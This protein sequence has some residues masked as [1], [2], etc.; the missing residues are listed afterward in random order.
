MQIIKRQLLLAL[1]I[2][3]TNVMA[4]AQS[5]TVKG[6]VTDTGGNPIIGASVKEQ[7]T[8]NA[9][10]TDVD[11]RFQLTVPASST[12]EISYIGY[13]TQTLKPKANVAVTLQ[14]QRSELNEVVVIG[15]GT[16]R[17]KDLTGSVV[18]IRP[19]Q[20]ADQNPQTVQDVLRGHAG[21]N[22]GYNA[23]AKGGGS[24]NIRGQRSV[25]TSNNHNSP[26]LILDGMMFYGELS[27]INPDDIAQ[28]DVLKD[29]SSAAI[30][31]AKAANGVIIIT[32]KKGKVGKPTVNL[33]A[34]VGFATKARYRDRMNTSQYL[35]H[36]QE[37]YEQNFYGTDENGNYGY[38]QSGTYKDQPGF[39]S[40]PDNLPSGVSLDQ[41]RSYSQNESG[42]SD[43][44]I[45]ARRLGFEGNNLANFLAGKTVDWQDLSMR[46][47]LQQDY[48]ASVSGA[49]DKANYYL[50]FG[51]L[52]N[53]GVFI[54][55]DYDAF[56][57]NM[58]V[59][60]KVTKWLELG[61]NVNFQD[62][63]DG[64][65]DMDE[66]YQL[67][68]SLWA[69]YRDADGNLVQYP[70]SSEYS[71]RGYNYEYEKQYLKLEKGYTVLNTI[72]NAT[73]SLPFDI[74]YRFNI[75]PRY[76]FFY[77][78][79]FMSAELPGSNPNDRGVNRNWGKRFDWSL[80]Q[81]ITWDHTFA[82]VHHITLTLGQ[83]AEER[84]YW[85]DGIEARNIQPTDALGFHNTQNGEKD[86]SSFSTN[87]T[88][89]TADALLGRLQYVYDD[90]YLLTT[91][92]RRDG[93]SAFG[94]SNPYAWFPSV[95][96]GWTFTNEKFWKW[97]D[98]M[99][100]GKLRLS[101]GKNGNRSLD[102]PYVALANL[103]SGGGKMMSYVTASGDLDMVKYLIMGRL[104]NPNLEWEKTTSYNFGLDFS[105]LKSRITGSLDVYLMQTKDMIMSQ[106][107]PGFSGF[108]SITS[109]LGQVDNNGFELTINS[110]NID[111]KDFKWE[112]TFNMAYNRN[113]I[114]HLYYE[115]EDVTDAQGNVIGQ[116]EMDDKS[117]GWFIGHP[118]NEIWDYKVTGI[119]QKD[120]V[121]EAAAHGQ[122]P[123]DPIVWNNP[124]ND[125]YND[126]G[127]VKTYVYNDDDKVFQGT[128]TPPWR[129]SM[130]NDFTLWKDL[131]LSVSM[132][133]Y[134]GAKSLETMYL[135][136]DDDGG[137]MT[138]AMA[139][140]QNKDYWTVN[141]PTNKYGRIQAMGPVGA[142][143]PGRL[144]N[145]SFLRVDNVSVSYILPRTW[146]TRAYISR[147]KVYAGIQNLLT[148]QSG[149]WKYYGDPETGGLAKR[150]FNIGVN[151]TF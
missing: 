84:K 66:D 67:R 73:V 124:D 131:T 19:D 107:L 85:S 7:G 96:V 120:Q 41:W 144:Y 64:N 141:N 13:E 112:T 22:V 148:I 8:R 119:W 17:K 10:V 49:S 12:I 138:Y 147:A 104:A 23:D 121:E 60:A 56:R 140:K 114:K 38:Y 94:S 108:S 135:N 116:K 28:I 16:A 45:W 133:S 76:E 145:R 118:I 151:L 97:Q 51:Y 18:Q 130:R 110:T 129:L 46:T 2:A 24:L 81:T 146:T 47:G 35:R 77:D 87:D 34:T 36:R 136:N 78:R 70:N 29:A 79:Y 9:T 102:D 57:A 3:M 92:L 113:R 100:Y 88:H 58:K 20:I 37:W 82:N 103:N 53:Q 95:A 31:G 50:S 90:R 71:Q 5:M 93:Y 63:S 54:D 106:R 48:N 61:A 43:L 69:D 117:N 137:R 55:D 149:D 25:Y 80:N 99:D 123:G 83:E 32:T 62:R 59:N 115:M 142:R 132:Y 52:N 98:I 40:N 65:I 122:R 109:N 75:S 126:D 21:L 143:T 11:G 26:L 68:N 42:E 39:Y 14:E 1:V 6:T 128:T 125:V 30:Y 4:F 33:T 111:H 91:T 27:E 139:T 89:Q 134:L 15:Y 105:F 86:A 74:T 44:S 150:V 72:F 101:Y 127:T